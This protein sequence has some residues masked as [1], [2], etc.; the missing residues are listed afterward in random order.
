M[1]DDGVEVEAPVGDG[2]PVVVWPCGGG[3]GATASRCCTPALETCE[4]PHETRPT[5]CG[6]ERGSAELAIER[7]SEAIAVDDCS[8][9]VLVVEILCDIYPV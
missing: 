9:N 8:T 1:G 6:V 3:G 2:L 7:A 4:S 5:L